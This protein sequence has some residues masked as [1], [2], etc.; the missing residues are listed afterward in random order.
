MH[1]PI[2]INNYWGDRKDHDLYKITRSLASSF[3]PKASSA[4]DVGSYIGALICDLEWIDKRIATDIQDLRKNWEGVDGV[5]FVMGDAFNLEFPDKF[6][7]VISNQTVE[8][9]EQPEVFVEKLLQLGRGLIL[10]TTYET[11]YGLIPG[12]IHDPID[13]AKFLSWF[14]CKLDGIAICY[15]PS[16]VIGHIIGVVKQSHPNLA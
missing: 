15:H 5:K 10:T 11:P 8:H 9:L 4:I 13:M 16:R 3:F 7:L 12:H 2:D 6:D 14:P 1:H